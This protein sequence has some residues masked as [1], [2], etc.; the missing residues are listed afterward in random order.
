[1]HDW[2]AWLEASSL[3][4]A[5]RNAGVWS[6]GIVNLIHLLG[7]STLFGSLLVL[8]LRLIG[9]WTRAPLA[10]VAIPTAPL[11][12]AGF[13]VAVLSG[14]CLLATNGTEYSDNPFLLLK[15]AAIGLGLLNVALLRRLPAW[16]S[17]RERELSPA[18]RRR[19]AIGGAVSLVCWTSAVACGRMIGYW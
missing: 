4:H 2:L 9:F 5:M 1:M 8:D 10:A 17:L 6:Y 12:Q 3:G 13:V 16:R 18:E 19:F 11:S 7:L 15:F 14:I